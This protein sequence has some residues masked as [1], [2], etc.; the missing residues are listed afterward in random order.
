MSSAFLHRVV[1]IIS[2]ENFIW[3]PGSDMARVSS[4]SKSK[5]AIF[6]WDKNLRVSEKLKNLISPQVH[7]FHIVLMENDELVS[8]D[9]AIANILNEYFSNVAKS[10]NIADNNEN[11]LPVDGISDPVTAAIA[12]YRSHPSVLLI[13]SH[14]E[15]VE[16]FSFRRATFVEVFKQVG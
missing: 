13:K 6:Y 9:R 11:L 2:F 15:D 16:A 12:K 1:S 10:L 5:L 14:C 7:I 8:E 3:L 4:F